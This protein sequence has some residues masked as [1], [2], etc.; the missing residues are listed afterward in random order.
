M[1]PT[2]REFITGLAALLVGCKFPAGK[3]SRN[4]LVVSNPI[5]NRVVRVYNS[6][7]NSWDYTTGVWSDYID[8]WQMLR[9]FNRGMLELT[10]ETD[11]GSA[12]MNALTG[13]QPFDKIVVKLNH[14]CYEEHLPNTSV[15]MTSIVVSSLINDLGVDPENIKVYDS[16]RN[17]ASFWQ[18]PWELLHPGVEYI[19]KNETHWDTQPILFPNGSIQYLPTHLVEADHLIN[20]NLMKGHSDYITGAMKNHFGTIKTPSS[21]HIDR[22]RQIAHLSSLSEIKSREKLCICEAALH[23][24]LKEYHEFE[25]YQY[26]DLFPGGEWSSL[27]FSRDAFSLDNVLADVINYERSYRGDYLWLNTFLD[28]AQN[29]Y[30]L[31]TRYA[32]QLVPGEFSAKDLHY[33]GIDYVSVN[34]NTSTGIPEE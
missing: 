22:H 10:E 34:V 17:I 18:A 19:T 7:M 15:T 31:G 20:L 2:R 30:G 33:E 26:Q 14:N 6:E 16:V 4:N 9:S 21:L 29:E 11:V 5:P 28:I 23:T 3:D 32:S 12:W 1:T 8:D 25:P 24:Y 27:M 13:Y